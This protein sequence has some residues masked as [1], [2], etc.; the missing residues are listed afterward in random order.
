MA[1]SMLLGAFDW[2]ED[3]FMS[4]VNLIPKLVYL[5]YTSLA[6]LLDVF[7]LFFRKLAGLD[8][9]YI[10]GEPVT[11]DL[12]TNF[13]TGIL[14]INPEGQTY[15]ALSTVFWS[16]IIFG[17][18]ICVASTLISVIKSHYTYDDKSAKGP[19][20]FVYAAIK[21]V[22]NMI[23]VPII[24]VLGLYVSEALLTA[25]DS[26]T[27]VSSG[28]VVSLYGDKVSNLRAIDSSKKKDGA[29]T[30]IYYDIY[31]FGSL[32][33][34]QT[35]EKLA[36][37]A[38][39]NA[40]FSGMLFKTAAYNAN[41][42]RTGQIAP[43]SDF[44]GCRQG[45]LFS[46]ANDPDVL[47]EMIDVAFAS[48]LHLAEGTSMEMNYSDDTAGEYESGKFC[49][50][51]FHAEELRAFSK[52]NVG[53]VWYYYNLWTFNFI[54]GFAG[55]IVCVT[56]F[57]NIILGLMT[58][59]FMCIGL[60]LINPPLFGLAPFD[61]G[62]AAKGWRDAFVKQVLMAYGAVIGMN[63]MFLILPYMN[64]ISFFNISIAD[65]LAQTLVLIVGLIT[66]KAFISVVSGLVGGEDANKAGEGIAK[67]VGAVAGKATKMTVGAVKGVASL[68]GNA[69]KAGKAAYHKGAQAVNAVKEHRAGKTIK[70]S[71][72]YT[73]QRDFL[74]N[75]ERKNIDEMDKG[76]VKAMAKEAGL[77]RKE[78]KQMWKTIETEGK[79]RKAAGETKFNASRLK[80][81]HE[82]TSK[83]YAAAATK[84]T[85][86]SGVAKM[87]RD[88]GA[89]QT[90]KNAAAQLK[91]QHATK[92]QQNK[93]GIAGLGSFAFTPVKNMDTIMKG[94]DTYKEFKDNSF[95]QKPDYAA[96]TAK[97]TAA[98]HGELKGTRRDMNTNADNTNAQLNSL[99]RFTRIADAR[100]TKALTEKMKR[101]WAAKYGRAPT[102]AEIKKIQGYIKKGFE[103]LP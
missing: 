89:A 83:K 61:G 20:Q 57:I 33:K 85:G 98:I 15:S 67:E 79:A 25:L 90:R 16:M 36:L 5:L 12:V 68:P 70:E 43:Q 6:C 29:K 52:F 78:T 4:V 17:L 44:S 66:I 74:A 77:S 97:N 60:F 88:V 38:A 102:S 103:D 7:Q 22:V 99:N 9:Y 27:S 28:T 63:I 101:Q 2:I 46:N 21:S 69:I 47:G 62:K 30:Y 1:S 18:I 91:T 100:R 49:D 13:I 14:G 39:T 59:L 65:Y 42:A 37:I 40:P 86:A 11:G 58:R 51:F 26:M 3:L 56:L 32:S 80:T 93:S 55:C 94:S 41:R 71:E 87:N 48:N 23:A 53:L 50:A 8:V 54:V 19:M 76:T 24:V 35:S 75:M 10:D 84:W 64:E 82:S 72:S 73:R 34:E 81:Q 95:W 92:Y 31:G 45:E 96:E